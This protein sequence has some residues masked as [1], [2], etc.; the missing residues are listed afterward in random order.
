VLTLDA[1]DPGVWKHLDLWADLIHGSSD[2]DRT[3]LYQEQALRDASIEAPTAPDLPPDGDALKKLGLVITVRSAEK[4]DLKRATELVNRTNQWNLCGARASFEQIRG[5]HISA[6]ALVLIASAADRFGDMG[7]V[8]VAIVTMDGE[9]AEIPILVLSCRVFGYGVE[10]AMLNEIIR[11]CSLGKER[12]TL[13]G[14][15]RPTN[16]NHACRNMY[17]DHGFDLVDG[18]FASTGSAP[19]RSLPWADVRVV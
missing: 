7:D 1:S 17:P 4:R 10:T 13:I 19:I 3:R 9:R 18:G 6:Q 16:Q 15:Y 2:L 11:R 8:C 12:R 14:R 5:W